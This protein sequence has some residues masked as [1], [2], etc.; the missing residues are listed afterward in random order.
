M[1]LFDVSA[2]P[3]KKE[4]APPSGAHKERVQP[5]VNQILKRRE[6]PQ[7]FESLAMG[8]QVHFFTKGAWSLDELLEYLIG[9][10]GPAQ[11][12]LTT[13]TVTE[14]PLRSI[15]R[16]IE[17]GQIVSLTALFDHRIDRR[18]PESLQLAMGM[19]ARIKLV[20]CHAKMLVLEN[21]AWSIAVVTSA[22]LSK[23]PRM[24]A[25][26]ISCSREAAAFH[27]NWIEN[28]FAGGN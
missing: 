4:S 3:V 1:S 9:I 17:E 14:T 10:T 6:F 18:K 19:N 11:V 8:D 16:L 22:N 12:W 20:K 21:E 26:V 28:E 24:E 2:R 5:R 13:W 7:A 23:N 27:K 25:G 15:C